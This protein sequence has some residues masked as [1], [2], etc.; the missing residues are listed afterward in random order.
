MTRYLTIFTPIA[1]AAVGQIV[2]KIG[3][4]NFPNL[5]FDSFKTVAKVFSHPPVAI[6]FILYGV[7]ALLWVL[8]LSREKL[9]FVYPLVAASYVI[10]VILSKIILKEEVPNLRWL[11]LFIIIIGI[12][13]IAKSAK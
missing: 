1:I 12:L 13:T 9:S 8:V 7:S 2:L 11:G 6:G 4:N 5:K 10:T 3:M